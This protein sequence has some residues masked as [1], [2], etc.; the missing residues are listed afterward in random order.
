VSR[1][2]DRCTSGFDGDGKPCD[3]KA[4]GLFGTLGKGLRVMLVEGWLDNP[5]VHE[6]FMPVALAPAPAHEVADGE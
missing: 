6:I 1:R 2:E 5:R 4:Y 3:W